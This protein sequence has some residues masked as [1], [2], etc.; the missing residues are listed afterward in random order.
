MD[1]YQIIL[2]DPAWSYKNY[3]YS[4]TKDGNK[5]KRG[6]VKEYSTMSIE[7]IRALPVNEIADDNCVL[8][9]WCVYALLPECISVMA[10]WGFEF[11]TCA[12]VW[13][14]TNKNT[15]VNQLSFLPVESFDTFWGMGNWTRSNTELCLLGVKGNPKRIN[16][17]VH[18]LIY[19]PIGKHSKKPKET[20]DRIVRLMGDLPRVELFARQ[21]TEG[22][23]C[24]GFD[25]DGKDLK[26][27][28]ETQKEI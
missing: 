15:N 16:A 7:D 25:I 12:F 26:E 22:W 24:M 10:A 21:K 8:F 11:K 27:S 3:N 14:K 19:A 1:K 28:L 18:Q 6:V 9:L 5:A 2:A 13:V 17:D 4:E 23:D 20:R